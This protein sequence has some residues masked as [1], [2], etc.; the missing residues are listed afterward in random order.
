M[1]RF[2]PTINDTKER[3]TREHSH[4]STSALVSEEPSNPTKRYIRYTA[5]MLVTIHEEVLR[6]FTVLYNPP[7]HIQSSNSVTGWEQG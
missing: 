2:H 7:S 4:I 3:V 1:N 5:A 6:T